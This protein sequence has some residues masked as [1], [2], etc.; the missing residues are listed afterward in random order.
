M[1]DK[2]I[3]EMGLLAAVDLDAA[4]DYIPIVDP[5]EADPDDQ[6]KRILI[7][8]LTSARNVNGTSFTVTG[9]T[10]PVN[11]AYLPAANTV[12]IATDSAM[13]FSVSTTAVVSTLPFSAPDGAEGTPAYSN[14]GDLNTGMWFSAADTVDFSAGG[15]RQFQVGNNSSA[16]SFL[17]VTG[18]QSGAAG[19]AAQFKADGIT[20]SCGMQFISKGRGE[21]YF[22]ERA[23]VNYPLARFDSSGGGGTPT[24][25]LAF[26]AGEDSTGSRISVA[27]NGESNADLWLIPRG[28]GGVRTNTYFKGPATITGT[29]VTGNQTI[30][31]MMGS[32]NFAAA[33]TAITVTNSLVTT[34]STIV[35]TVGTNDTT[36]KSV[37]V[38]AGPGSFVLNANA[39]ATAETRVNFLVVNKGD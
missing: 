1:T 22:Y 9:S 5:S 14:T 13:R 37:N 6:N 38:V 26:T 16:T 34:N 30:N 33:A 23:S 20:G 29:G 19:F 8:S 39:A 32:V 15:I 36:L 4:V 17:T 3:S 18:G 28:T 25:Y 10:V 7:D 35:A 21:F 27:N 11:G 24:S 2:T 12:G 31:K